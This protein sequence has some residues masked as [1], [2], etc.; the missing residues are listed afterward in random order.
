MKQRKYILMFF[1]VFCWLLF[2][3]NT[4]CAETVQESEPILRGPTTHFYLDGI[5]PQSY[6][7]REWTYSQENEDLF[8]WIPRAEGDKNW[9]RTL[10]R[11]FEYMWRANGSRA[12]QLF[13][14]NTT[15]YSGIIAF[16]GHMDSFGGESLP[17]FETQED[18][19]LYMFIHFDLSE[20]KYRFYAEDIANN[21]ILYDEYMELGR[22]R[23]NLSFSLHQVTYEY[24]SPV[25][26]E[27][28]DL[29]KNLGEQVSDWAEDIVFRWGDSDL[30]IPTNGSIVL[31]PDNL[32]AEQALSSDG[33]S[34]DRVGSII[35]DYIA[36]DTHSLNTTERRYAGDNT[37]ATTSRRIT[38]RTKQKPHLLITYATGAKHTDGTLLPPDTP[39]TDSGDT[40]SGGEDGWTNQALDIK[41]DPDT[42]QGNFDTVL[43]IDGEPDEIANNGIATRDNYHTQSPTTSGIAVRGFL[44]EVELIEK[45]LSANADG[46]VKIDTTKPTPDIAH[47]NG[48]NFEDKSTDDLSGISTIKN[49]TRIAFSEVGGSQPEDSDF[50]EIGSLP[51]IPSGYYDIW[52]WA[53]DLAGNKKIEMK[54]PD[55]PVPGEVTISKDTAN[56]A[57]LHVAVCDN[58]ES[59]KREVGCEEDCEEGLGVEIFEKSEIT[60]ELTLTNTDI[61]KAASGT[62]EDYLPKGVTYT[63]YEA[64]P[65][66]SVTNVQTSPPETSGE[67]EGQIKVTGDYTIAKDSQIKLSL[68]GETPSFDT[69]EG[70]SNIISNQA[71]TTWTI[72][73]VNDTNVSNYANHEIEQLLGTPTAF[74][75]VGAD[76]LD[77]GLGGAEFALYAWTGAGTPDERM[78]DR[79]ELI[80]GDWVRVKAD[81]EDATVLSDIF[82]SSSVAGEEGLVDL[83]TLPD[84]AYTLIETK[85]PQA[86]GTTS[87]ELPAGQW[88]IE[89]DSS[90]PDTTLDGYKIN[91]T[92]KSEGVMPPAATRETKDGEIVYKIINTHPFELALAGL[93]GTRIFTIMGIIL[94]LGA[95]VTYTIIRHKQSSSEASG[96]K[97]QHEHEEK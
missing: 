67:Y 75:K 18:P 55:F 15:Q 54:L 14:E 39:Y 49:P 64:T 65:A 36:R 80:D 96:V 27:N 47:V 19:C 58:H 66:G 91:F 60:Y 21:E 97:R 62:F 41:V 90:K 51:P 74:T 46:Q 68:I 83:G 59:I 43:R 89:I 12:T 29:V 88:S 93:S 81:G 72:E 52:V 37:F 28:P 7:M 82:V 35:L 2:D 76:D 23:A 24:Y 95:G 71:S 44:S 8:T 4:L 34:F 26:E 69:S 31:D 45:T 78:V 22:N 10:S 63:S 61:D 53:T 1:I 42:I 11:Q 94:M 40:D 57:T 13:W 6:Y 3:T 5:S 33:T 48:M 73:A 92:G 77:T 86:S 50:H 84:G 16:N 9:T 32:G 79:D 85:V 17:Y 87:Y 56:G 38:V 70:A 25:L 30:S 20:R